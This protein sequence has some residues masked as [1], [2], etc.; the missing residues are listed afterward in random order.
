MTG[1]A[2]MGS[3]ASSLMC[4]WCAEV[5]TQKVTAR[6]R[7]GQGNGRGSALPVL[8]MLTQITV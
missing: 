1:H 4:V 3:S 5:H 6:V 8:N 2:A 7:R